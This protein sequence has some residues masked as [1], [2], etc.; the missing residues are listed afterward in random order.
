MSPFRVKSFDG[1]GGGGSSGPIL[2]P[3]LP[4]IGFVT[5]GKLLQ[6]SALNSLKHPR[7]PVLVAPAVLLLPRVTGAAPCAC[8][9]NRAQGAER[10]QHCTESHSFWAHSILIVLEDFPSNRGP[11]NDHI[12]SHR[13]AAMPWESRA[14]SG[15]WC[16]KIQVTVTAGAF[17]SRFAEIWI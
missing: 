15:R 7:A 3:A 4:L 1:E 17:Y 12:H 10:T 2:V 6:L 13:P 14:G 8:R 11:S 9:V 5:L 16:L